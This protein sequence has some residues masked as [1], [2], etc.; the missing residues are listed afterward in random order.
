MDTTPFE[1]LLFGKDFSFK[2][3]LGDIT[4][5]VFHI[6][7]NQLS[8]GEL[9]VSTTNASF[10]HLTASGARYRLYYKDEFISSGT[11]DMSAAAG[12]LG[13][14]ATT[15]QLRD[16][17]AILYDSVGWQVPGSGITNQGAAEYDKRTGNA[18]TIL[19]GFVAANCR[20][21][22]GRPVIVATNQNRGAVITGGIRSRMDSLAEILLGPVE[23]A[24]LGVRFRNTS[25]T[26]I[27]CD[28][29]EITPASPLELSE[30]SGAVLEFSWTA[31][32]PS[33]TRAVVGGSEE[34]K[35]RY[36][37]Q[38]IDTALEAT[39]G[40]IAEIYVDAA[41]LGDDLRDAV[42]N[43]DNKLQAMNTA[44]DDAQKAEQERNAADNHR[45]ALAASRDVAQAVGGSTYTNAVT[46]Y[47][48]A[49]AAYA[50]ANTNYV[51]KNN[52]LTTKTTEFATAQVAREQAILDHRAELR[53]R[54]KERV[55]EGAPTYGF[56]LR[57]GETENFSYGGDGVHVGDKV[58][59]NAGG[60]VKTDL[61]R[62]VT[63]SW[64]VEEG[65]VVTP[66]VGE[67]I[68]DQPN[69]ALGKLI[70]VA[71][72]AIRKLKAGR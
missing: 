11:I 54:G 62:S 23:K 49:N 21:R 8:T 38:Y 30:A 56:S 66:V 13:D 9:K 50:T 46:K 55:A 20:D 7:H 41:D 2:A 45:L 1:L 70:A 60:L 39:Y 31:Q 64:T 44:A 6:R 32:N 15:F 35:K 71:F 34:K 22:Q 26:N 28:V 48:A 10:G 61:L 19:K 17:L 69:K 59:V 18:E 68:Q 57:L 24:G 43:V 3:V 33:V 16:D 36:F 5:L 40:T 42:T 27:V 12:P 4:Y 67:D 53:D 14:A 37:E 65:L 52:I 51:N 63:I 25:G 47:N 72:S 29:Y 58:T